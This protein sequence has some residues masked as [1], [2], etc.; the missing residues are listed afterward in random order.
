MNTATQSH[1]AAA[2]LGAE[3]KACDRAVVDFSI[4]FRSKTAIERVCRS[5]VNRQ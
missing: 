1:K 4:L 3:V 5:A 2:L